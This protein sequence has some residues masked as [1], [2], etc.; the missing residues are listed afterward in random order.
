M[1][2]GCDQAT[3]PLPVLYSRWVADI[4]PGPIPRETRATCHACAMVQEGKSCGPDAE[5]MF[6]PNAKC[7][8]YLPELPNFLVGAVLANGGDGGATV[9]AGHQSVVERIRRRTA[10]TPLGLGSTP[11]FDTVYGQARSKLFGRTDSIR[12][13]HFVDSEGG[14]CGIW[15]YRNSVCATWFCKHVRGKIGAD[16]WSALQRLLHNVEK[17]LAVW[18]C[19]ECGV[20]PQAICT[21]LEHRMRPMALR[22]TE[23]LVGDEKGYDEVWGSWKGQEDALFKQAWECVRG[24]SWSVVRSLGGP[25]I[26]A[27]ELEIRRAYLRLVDHSVPTALRYHGARGAPSGDKV[28]VWSHNQYDPITIPAAA[29]LHVSAF[30]GRAVTDVRADLP[31]EA[32]CA[33][34]DGVLQ[35]LIDHGILVPDSGMTNS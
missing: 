20:D 9:T 27:R 2:P 4:L 22:L 30:D 32:L 3:E 34:D 15:D 6:S 10:V 23:E 16:F 25:E 13:P 21:A 24:T 31:E 29:W 28:T 33:L 11:V 26:R 8:T 1:T 14:L 19:L 12:C 18:C 35:R 7:C 17:D 5:T